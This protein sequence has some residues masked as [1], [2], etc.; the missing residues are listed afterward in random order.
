LLGITLIIVLIGDNAPEAATLAFER[1]ARSVLGASASVQLRHAAEDPDDS[2]SVALADGVDGV[3]ELSWSEDG[4]GARVHCYLSGER[5]W[6][7]REIKFG[8]AGDG[9]E[10]EQRERGRLLGFAVATMFGEDNTRFVPTPRKP[11]IIAP[12]QAAARPRAARGRERSPARLRSLEFAGIVS[13][14]VSGTASGIGAMAG[15]RLG[16]VGPLAARGFVAGR[17]GN[18]PEAQASTRTG[19]LGGG[20]S[21]GFL[22][23]SSSWDVGLRVDGIVSY[24]EA[25]H[26]SEDDA[27]PDRRQRWLGGADLIAEGGLRLTASAGLYGGAGIEAM[28]GSTEVYTHGAR[29]AVVPPLRTVAELG[30]RTRF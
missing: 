9:R 20:L 6:V 14:G 16:L 17:A 8:G 1:A 24:F 3:V 29:V 15:V 13:S 10:R 7:D 12:P 25:S 4:V 26:L 18:I 23:L 27:A 28:F 11:S 21:V 22:P 2:D 19:Q 5:R 30:F